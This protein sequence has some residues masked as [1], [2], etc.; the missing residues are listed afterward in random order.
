[1]TRNAGSLIIA[2]DPFAARE[3]VLSAASCFT[4]CL[5]AL[6]KSNVAHVVSLLLLAGVA[7]HAR[8][9]ELARVRLRATGEQ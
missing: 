7:P 9:Q 6:L 1:M 8:S 3:E 4:Q 2:H 5:A